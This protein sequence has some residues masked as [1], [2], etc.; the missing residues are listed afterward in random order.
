MLCG[1]A[2]LHRRRST[3]AT[4]YVCDECGA[5]FYERDRGQHGGTGT[6]GVFLDFEYRKAEAFNTS[7]VEKR[8]KFEGCTMLDYL[9]YIWNNPKAG[10]S[11]YK[12]FEGVMRPDGIDNDGNVVY[13]WNGEKTFVDGGGQ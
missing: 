10:Q 3:S 6:E 5:L 13:V 11:P 1:S 9:R 2:R 7:S 4:T 8:A 12:M